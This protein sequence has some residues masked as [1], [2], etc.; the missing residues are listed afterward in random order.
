MVNLNTPEGQL[1]LETGDVSDIP[2]MSDAEYTYILSQHDN[3]VKDSVLD[4]LYAILARLSYKTDQRLDRI[5]F[6][7]SQS[8]EQYKSFVEGK[9]KQIQ[10]IGIV[11]N[12]FNIYAGGISKTDAAAYKADADLIQWQNPFDKCDDEALR[13]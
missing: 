11:A 13:W 2:V 6:W 7:G 12:N 9:I 10:G 3:I 8:Y 5:Q 4:A 1:R